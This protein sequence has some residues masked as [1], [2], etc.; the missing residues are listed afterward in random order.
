M[1]ELSESISHFAFCISHLTFIRIEFYINITLDRSTTRLKKKKKRIWNLGH[2]TY[3]EEVNLE[4]DHLPVLPWEITDAIIDHLHHDVQ[5]L[6][7][8]GIVCSE[9]LIRSRY[10]IFST[11]QLWPWRVRRFFD[12]ATS[13][14][15]TFANHI[16]RIEVDDRRKRSREQGGRRLSFKDQL[17]GTSGE[18][19]L[20]SD[21]MSQ[22]DIPC[23]AQVRSIQVQNVDWTGLSLAQQ[24]VLRGQ[25]AK[26]SKLDRLE[27]QGVVF[28]DLREVV[29]IV[30]C[31]PSLSHLTANITFMKYLE[32]TMSA[33]KT[34]S[35]S[36]GLR[37]IELGTE[38]GI[39][40]VLSYVAS[41]DGPQHVVGLK[42]EKIKSGHL[43]H[44][45]NAFRKLGRNLQRLSL[46]FDKVDHGM[47]DSAFVSLGLIFLP[48]FIDA[49][50]LSHLSD[51]RVLRLDGLSVS[52]TN[53][54]EVLPEILKRIES[55][56][57]ESI[58]I[59]FRPEC[60][61]DAECIDW[62]HLERVLLGLHFFSL[63]RV[64]IIGEIHAG[65]PLNTEQ[66][67]RRIYGGM[68][69]LFERGVL[70]VRVDNETAKY[71]AWEMVN[72]AS[73]S[74]PSVYD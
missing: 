6:G 20:F 1:G 5:T 29:R 2:T 36:T 55:P 58:G 46:A 23:L 71:D 16:K 44:I 12:L 41:L 22:I 13:K 26:F 19:V 21:T 63:R 42:L 73:H 37:T 24:V 25:L 64:Q 70:G 33:A 31:L 62:S 14:E 57:L 3:E 66:L 18:E 47:L 60:E 39:P 72:I 68:A 69:D 15:C 11:I 17:E 61:S 53:T 52:K 43:Q 54:E 45:R 65:S 49:L 7:I 40:A 51:L 74:T 32:H 48:D 8:C 38:D 50:D 67:E 30:N 34:L 4:M 56:F 9:W 35:L 10:H 59:K 28:H 27:F